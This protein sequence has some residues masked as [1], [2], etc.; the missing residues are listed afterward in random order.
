M[1]NAGRILRNLNRRDSLAPGRTSLLAAPVVKKEKR[2]FR[3]YVPFVW[4]AMTATCLG[5][6]V[7]VVG[8]GLCVVGYYAD[9]LRPPSSLQ[10]RRLDNDTSAAS[11]VENDDATVMHSAV[12][13]FGSVCMCVCMYVCLYVCMHV[14]MYACVYVGVCLTRGAF[15]PNQINPLKW[16]S[17]N[18]DFCLCKRLV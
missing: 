15:L 6:I 14:C 11:W 16:F 12:F 5:L 9:R 7:I 8:I 2:K 13:L 1:F 17:E 18:R 3:C 10:S 4:Q